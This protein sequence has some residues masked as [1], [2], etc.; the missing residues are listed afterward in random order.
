[1]A[2]KKM[3]PDEF[4]SLYASGERDFMEVEITDADMSRAT[5]WEKNRPMGQTITG[6]C[7]S[8]GSYGGTNFNANDMRGSNFSESKMVQCQFIAADL[9]GT[10]WS[11]AD[12]SRSTFEGAKLIRA[13]F[14]EAILA[15]CDFVGADLTEADFTGADISGANF[16]GAL[17]CKTT[18]PDG[19]I[20]EGPYTPE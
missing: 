4:F 18:M 19:S 5:G 12:L 16:E 6:A 10:G 3:T 9:T 2:I 20:V 13:E 15:G 14:L 8:C 11:Y 17:F 1:M 7:M